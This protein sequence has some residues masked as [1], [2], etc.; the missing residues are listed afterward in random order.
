MVV[1]GGG[2][3]RARYLTTKMELAKHLIGPRAV[4]LALSLMLCPAS[5]LAQEGAALLRA[6]EARVDAGRENAV[7]LLAPQTFRAAVERFDDAVR[8]WEDGREDAR[9]RELL[10]EAEQRLEDAEGIAAA[11]RSQFGEPLAARSEARSAEAGTRARQAWESA[12]RELLEAGRRFE[13]DDLDEAGVRAAR[14]ADLYRRAARAGW[15]DRF[16]GAAIQARAAAMTAGASELAPATFAEGEALL[17]S[18]GAD[19]EMNRLEDGPGQAG[20]AALVAFTRAHRIATLSDSVRRR[21]VLLE[22]LVDEHEDDLARLAEAA[23]VTPQR[24]DTG[25]TTSRL[26]AEIERIR[27]DNARL[28]EDLGNERARTSDLESRLASAEGRL[29]EFEQRFTGAR[30]ELLAIREREARLREVQGLFTASEGEVLLTG[31]R[32][33]LRLHGLTFES[34]EAEISESLHPLLAKVQRVITTF[35]GAAVRIEGHTDAQGGARGNQALSQRRAIAVR[36]HILSRVPIPS[37]R[38]EAVG[39]GEDRPIASNET[40]EGRARNRRIEVVVT[41]PGG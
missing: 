23:G 11:G 41:P 34:S 1:R 33:V 38:V 4:W 20:E 21:E 8:R 9:F 37:S 5:G 6:M 13:R 24:N 18:G 22:R 27:A 15:R 10:S 19:I 40:E 35:P 32:I 14:A 7:H 12:E 36:E 31:D 25:E 39:L 16:L 3:D 17:A 29:I 28:E 2:P 30:D 26:A